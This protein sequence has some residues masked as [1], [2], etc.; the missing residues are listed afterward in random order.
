M[1]RSRRF[2]LFLGLFLGTITAYS[3]ETFPRNDVLD[4]RTH[5][6]AFTNATIVVD[7]STTLENATLLIKE[8]VIEQ[9]G[10]NIT[11]PKGYSTVDLHGKFIYPSFV[12]LHSNYGL[13]KPER[14]RGGG[15]GGPEQINSNSKG[16]YNANEAIK[17]H[18]NAGE[19]FVADAKTATSF[20]KNG[21]GAVLT[22]MHDGIARGSSALVSFGEDSENKL[23]LNHQAAAHYSLTKGTSTQNYP[24]SM[25]GYIS[26]LRQTHLDAEW[27]GA[28]SPRPFADQTLEAWI[29]SQR[30]PQIFDAGSWINVL[31][32]DKIGDEFN[33]RYIIKGGG[34][35]YKRIK[36]IKATNASL[37]IPVK[38]PDPYDV[39][40]P[41][42]A[43]KVSLSDMKHWELAPTNAG[44]LDANNITF[45][46]TSAGAGGDFLSNIRKAIK[47]GLSPNTA[48]KALTSGPASMLQMQDRLGKLKSGMIANFL[49]TS[50]AIF[51]EKTIIHENW[52]QGKPFRMK[53]LDTKDHSGVYTLTIGRDA[54]EMEISGKPGS[55]KS[56][57]VVND[58]TSVDIKSS[59]DK[60]LITFG[61][62]TSKDD[63]DA[64]RLSGWSTSDGW[65]GTG[66]MVDGAWVSWTALRTGDATMKNDQ[67][68]GRPGGGKKEDAAVPELGKIV[69]PF[70]AFGREKL[71]ETKSLLIKN[72]TV[73]T[74]ESDGILTNTDVLLENG[75]IAR[76]EKN[77][78][79]SGA[80]AIDGTG[81]HLTCGIIDEHTH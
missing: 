2:L 72:A 57:L 16:A 5:A 27:F 74:N 4:E 15:F 79:A 78:N 9:V 32:A 55:H 46:L 42:D 25:M 56:K 20:R 47:H 44:V 12:E 45:A 77:L 39:D 36:E 71:P 28:Q 1:I 48:L 26:L 73:W 50:G 13:P 68:K 40:D 58:S 63:K 7:H 65:K 14:R 53:P 64:I 49:I 67:R 35:E 19:V 61:I 22:S 17:A 76:I 43:E 81:K 59:F 31:R 75:K 33:V 6:Y 66:Q 38:Y 60:D 34:D 18:F 10:A 29:H 51:D 70:V 62:K 54:Y 23:V 21:F 52:V 24:S 3:Q 11:I 80:M 30:L 41:I 37:I 8:G 69:Y